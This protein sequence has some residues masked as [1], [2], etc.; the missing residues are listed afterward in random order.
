MASL[1]R[2]RKVESMNS[3]YVITNMKEKGFLHANLFRLVS[4]YSLNPSI[5]D[6][7]LTERKMEHV[8]WLVDKRI[9]YNNGG[10]ML[11]NA[12]LDIW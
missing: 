6:R 8:L 7:R 10:K 1:H 12:G 3:L 4:E 5:N 2:K 11:G 9:L